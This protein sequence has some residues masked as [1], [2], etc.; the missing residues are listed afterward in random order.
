MCAFDRQRYFDHPLRVLDDHAFFFGIWNCT[1][2][3]IFAHGWWLI[4][5]TQDEQIFRQCGQSFGFD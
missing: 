3:T 1:Q 5:E 4:G 2:E